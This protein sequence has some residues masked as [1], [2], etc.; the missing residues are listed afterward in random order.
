MQ[1][2]WVAPQEFSQKPQNTK[3]G[4]NWEENGLKVH[5]T[6]NSLQLRDIL[7]DGTRVDCG[8]VRTVYAELATEIVCPRISN[9][10]M[11]KHIFPN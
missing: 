6:E 11:A 5:H 10:G 2:F 8:S 9:V 4:H 3:R 1:R 7:R